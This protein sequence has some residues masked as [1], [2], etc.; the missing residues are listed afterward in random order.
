[1]QPLFPE[2]RLLGGSEGEA[3]T[4]PVISPTRHQ[5]A[6]PSWPVPAPDEARLTDATH[7]DPRA[8]Q[9]DVD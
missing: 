6:A 9:V 3:A 4:D 5:R 2:E 8:A 1:V 7:A